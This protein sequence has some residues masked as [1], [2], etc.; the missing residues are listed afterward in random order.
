MLKIGH[1]GAPILAP[2]NTL[3]SFRQ[4]I[5]CGV[6]MIE[7]DIQLTKDNQLVVFHDDDL[8]RIVGVNTRVEELTLAKLKEFDIGSSFDKDF[9]EERIPTLQ[10]VI[11]LV[12]GQVKLNIE[13]KPRV[14]N[15]EVLLRKLVVLLE[16]E[17]FKDKVIISSFNHWLLKDLKEIDSTIKTAILIAS[18]PINPVK[19]I[20]D[21]TADGIHPHHLVVTKELV[22]KVQKKGY[23]LNVWT[24]NNQVEVDKLQSYGVDGII[25]DN[26]GKY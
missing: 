7:L 13:L 25:T 16:E 5:T 10:E 12:K 4:A 17:Q 20:E 23:F 3:A 24:V 18:L 15:R 8:S 11:Q 19:M 22:A 9:K 1:R 6:D 26:P 14:A 2:E 21:A